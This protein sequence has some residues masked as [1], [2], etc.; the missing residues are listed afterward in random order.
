MLSDS[1]FGTPTMR[2]VKPARHVRV[3]AARIKEGVRQTRVHEDGFPACD[4]MDSYQGVDSFDLVSA[5]GEA[6]CSVAFC[7]GNSA[8]DCSE[9]FQIFLEA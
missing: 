3:Y 6:S 9:A 2:L 1:A 4:W 7:L 8:V 5:N